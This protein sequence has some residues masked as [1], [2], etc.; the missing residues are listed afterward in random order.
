MARSRVAMPI[1]RRGA[2]LVLAGSLAG[3]VGCG[4]DQDPTGAQ[5]IWDRVHAEAY[6]SWKRAPGYETRKDSNT[7]HADA[8][9]IYV[10]ST[11]DA[12]ITSGASTWPVGSLIVKDGWSGST[13]KLVALMEKRDSG[14]YWA[15]YDADE[16]GEATYS[17]SPSVCTGCH[18][19]GKDYVRFWSP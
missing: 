7:S 18:E 19:S 14:W 1:T 16:G 15:E 12:A 11:M 3:I 5:E 17:G 4:D 9:D 13:H 2:V 8:V 6:T 10:N